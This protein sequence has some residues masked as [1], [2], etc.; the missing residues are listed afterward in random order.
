MA[1]VM[2]IGGYGL[3]G[4]AIVHAARAQGHAVT[5]LGR[6]KTT[7]RRVLPDVTWHI[8]DLRD[9]TDPADWAPILGGVDV[10]VNAAGALQD[11][12]ADHLDVVHHTAPAALFAACAAQDVRVVQISA[13]GVAPGA[14]T[15]FLR[16]KAMGD[17]ALV[18]SGAPHVILRP[19]LV[20]S[21]TAYGGTA[22]LRMLAAVPV[23]QPL[24]LPEAQ[25]QTIDMDDLT[26]A[27]N[28]AI[29]GDLSDGA[30][31]DLV[32]ETPVALHQLVAD[33]RQWLGFAPARRVI[34]LPRMATSAVGRI[35]DALGHLGWRSP[36]RSTAMQVLTEGVLG[37][38]A[39]AAAAG[40]RPVDHATTLRRMPPAGVEA[41]LHA[42][43]ALLMPVVVAV[44]IG[45]W[46]LSGLA[47]LFSLQDAAGHLTSA[48]WSD[49]AAGAAVVFWSL[50][51]VTL[52]SGLAWRRSARVALW[53]MVVVPAIY[54]GAAT[55]VT[56]WLWADPL[57]PLVK[58]IPA[59]VLA[60]VALPMIEA[61]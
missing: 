17:A 49:A 38:P 40:L 27:V 18:A 34:A 33:L 22:L 48:G 25:I 54:V 8:A 16:T 30:S 50:V 7:A 58:A 26:R 46:S 39:P 4:A 43:M 2:V 29:A 53:G 13:V 31:L 41:R 5:A 19:G 55:V 59:A 28:A 35:A 9:L 57:G 6:S 45:F 14:D 37:D 1:K 24:A 51:D 52:A 32:A 3:I 10:V 42:R 23:V 61:R 11:G 12:P 56:P 47:G 15:A 36:L 60:L 20:L 21:Q 44:L